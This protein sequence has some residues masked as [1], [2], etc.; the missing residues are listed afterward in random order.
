MSCIKIDKPHVVY[1]FSNYDP[2]MIPLIAVYDFGLHHLE[3]SQKKTHPHL[4][5]PDKR[6]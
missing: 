1:I 3:S 5:A 6:A 2:D 4:Q